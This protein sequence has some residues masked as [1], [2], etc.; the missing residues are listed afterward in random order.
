MQ[1]TR[2]ILFPS[3]ACATAEG[4]SALLGLTTGE[5]NT[6]LG[7][8][9]LLVT[10]TG[11]D[12]TG[13]GYGVM[14][15]N[16]TGSN[17][18]ANGVDT[19]LFNTIGSRNTAIGF[20]ALFNNTT[21]NDNIAL[22]FQAGYRSTG[23]NNI[24]IGNQGVAGDSGIIRIGTT[25]THR[26]TTI[27]GISG[28]TVADG[29]AVMIDARGRLGTLT[30]SP[31]YKEGIKPMAKASEALLSLKPVTFHYR[32]ELDPKSLPQFGLVAEDVAKVDPDLVARDEKGEPYTV[33]YEA[34]NGCCSTNS[35]RRIAS[36]RSRALRLPS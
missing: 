8:S 7:N 35:S 1:T 32:K 5:F 6:A 22:G 17:N 27:A 13:T 2:L 25:G 18:T 34:V 19:L 28:I 3:L 33:R 26:N 24:D 23:S 30:S 20:Y 10:T 21:A 9:G 4:D 14:A 31:R 11:S 15:R 16:T 36:W 29:V 12:N